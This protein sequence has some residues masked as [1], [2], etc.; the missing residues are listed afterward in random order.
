MA[1][2]EHEINLLQRQ[3]DGATL[4]DHLLAAERSGLAAPELVGPPLPA[5][6]AYL[7]GWFLDLSAARGRSGFG[8]GPISYQDIAA[9]AW[10]HGIAPSSFELGVL[11]R[12][13]LAFLRSGGG[14]HRG[15]HDDR[16]HRAR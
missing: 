5:A 7:W 10:L 12:L 15:S 14:G 1:Y 11:R 6:G 9:W 13:D 4:R 8:L 2:G 3:P 16:N